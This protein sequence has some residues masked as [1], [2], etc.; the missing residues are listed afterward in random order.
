M[1]DDIL[2]KY[3]MLCSPGAFIFYSCNEYDIVDQ[4]DD[5]RFNFKI[6]FSSSIIKR[7]LDFSISESF[8]ILDDFY[9]SLPN[10]DIYENIAN[11]ITHDSS[12]EYIINN[13]QYAGASYCIAK[14]KELAKIASEIK[15]NYKAIP[16][17]EKLRLGI[18]NNLVSGRA[19][20][21]RNIINCLDGFE[22][23]SK[24]F[25]FSKFCGLRLI[26]SSA[27]DDIDTVDLFFRKLNDTIDSI[28]SDSNEYFK[29]QK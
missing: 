18:N 22:E 2:E 23:F 5:V 4:K 26:L 29:R 21:I 20:E 27:I 28:H 3:L 12:I 13:Y 16:N 9:E 19:D 7:M 1:I 11:N 17:E 10:K 15:E 24:K 14:F 8:K 25:F 6:L